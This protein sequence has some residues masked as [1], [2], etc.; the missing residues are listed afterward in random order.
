MRRR[1]DDTEDRELQDGGKSKVVFAN[2]RKL[3]KWMQ[4][5]GAG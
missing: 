1:L 4:Y 3:A 5:G 2:M